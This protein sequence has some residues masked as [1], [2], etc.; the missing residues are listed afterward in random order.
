MSTQSCVAG[1]AHHPRCF[2]R[3]DRVLLRTA[4]TSDTHRYIPLHVVTS[5]A[6][7]VFFLE[8]DWEKVKTAYKDRGGNPIKYCFQ[9]LCGIAS[10]RPP[11]V[12]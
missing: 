6:Q 11:L 5:V 9:F 10:V 12:T 3:P 2:A 1:S 8:K 4:R 7:A